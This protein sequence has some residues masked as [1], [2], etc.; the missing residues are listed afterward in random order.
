MALQIATNG[1]DC[2]LQEWNNHMGLKMR[3][4]ANGLKTRA[5]RQ[6][7]IEEKA[8]LA[9]PLPT[10]TSGFIPNPPIQASKI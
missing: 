1:M 4:K 3:G 10:S 2:I 6:V 8:V 7:L 5:L 9:K